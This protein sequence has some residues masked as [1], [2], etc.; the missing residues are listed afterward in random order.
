MVKE[1]QRNNTLT[2]KQ[3]VFP[4]IGSIL[5]SGVLTLPAAVEASGYLL[6]APILIFVSGICAFTLYQ[7][8]HCAKELNTRSPSYFKVCQNTHPILGYISE[9]CIGIQ[10]FGA[11]TVY[12]LIL[13]ESILSLINME[14]TV[15]YMP[16]NIMCSALLLII[17]TALAM[18]KS[19]KKLA[20]I[21]VLSTISV[22]FLSFVVLLSGILA[23]L[24]PKGSI[25]TDTL[26]AATNEP[27]GL[28]KA[29][30]GYIFGLGCQQNMV[31]VFSLLK[32]PTKINGAKVG[33]YAIV[34]VSIAYFFVANGGYIA[35]GNGQNS[36]ILDVLSNT[37]KPFYKIIM[38]N[39]GDTWGKTY[40]HL[41]TISKLAM[42]IV[43]LGA[44]PLQ[45]HPT[46]DSIITFLSII[47]K[48]NIFRNNPRVVEVLIT[49]I[50][51]I[52]VFIESLYKIKYI[53]VMKL[54]AS[55][56]SCYIM[57]TLPSIA[58]IYSQ[59]KV[60][61][62]DYTSKFILIGSILFSICSTYL[63]L[64]KNNN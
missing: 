5:G 26:K 10:G 64:H 27:E 40:F 56:A 8:V 30:S 52:T 16:Y 11:I 51:T 39:F 19:L 22:I 28:F 31:K 59:N 14:D 32:N 41:I 63:L 23:L 3:A 21:S 12:L 49:S 34:I 57:F 48:N 60:K 25:P 18:Q 43:L 20:F 53:S 46:R 36:S 1:I 2:V 54:I 24:L 55:T 17:P 15:D 7:L 6:S 62:F 42:V 45:L 4:M 47:F 58:Y 44:Y 33:T 37:E 61:L 35:G 13:K 9:V 50:M 29:L 38:T